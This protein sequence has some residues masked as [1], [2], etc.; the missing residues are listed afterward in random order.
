MTTGPRKN[1]RKKDNKHLMMFLG[2][3]VAIILVAAVIVANFTVIKDT[4]NGMWYR[5]TPEMEQIRASLNL[6]GTGYRIFNASMPELMERVEFN[7]VCREVENEAA[8]LG[9]YT[10][11]KIYIFNIVDDELLGIKELTTA[12]EL[13]HAVYNRMSEGDKNRWSGVLN[14]VYLDNKEVLGEEIDLYKDRQKQEEL[15][16]RI[17]TEIKNLPEELEKHYAE[18]F[19]DQ[20][21]VVDFYES[22]ITVFREIEQKLGELQK[23]IES[24]KTEID[25]KTTKYETGAESLNAKI[26]EFNTCAGTMNCFGTTREFNNKRAAIIAEQESVKKLYAEIDALIQKYNALIN[27][28]NQNILHGQMLNMTI[29]SSMSLNEQVEEV[30][31]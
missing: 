21:K 26:K 27:E 14:E 3:S 18:I 6:T 10:D 13:L 25:D 12:H 16:V 9:C 19:D 17:G 28:Y 7:S 23:Q 30:E 20:D 15:Y 29:N 22:Y 2:A 4:V 8:I 24:L 1:E 5:P 11:D 31:D